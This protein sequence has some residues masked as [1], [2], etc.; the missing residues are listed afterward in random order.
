MGLG[1]L[2]AHGADRVR[3]GRYIKHADA[4]AAFWR[5][6]DDARF[7]RLTRGG[8]DRGRRGR[9]IPDLMEQ[10]AELAADALDARNARIFLDDRP[11]MPVMA[12]DDPADRL[13]FHRV[14]PSTV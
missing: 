11:A 1:L 10:G 13:E 9:G 14:I 8:V 2:R 12:S 3:F 7:R 6:E 4:G 5:R